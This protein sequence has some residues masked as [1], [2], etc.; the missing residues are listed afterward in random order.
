[1]GLS[2]LIVVLNSLRLAG[3][4]EPGS[5][6]WAAAGSCVG[7]RGLALSVALPGGAVRRLVLIGQVVSPARGQSLL[8]TLP[9]ITTIGLPNG[10]SAETYLEPG[11]VG[12]EPVPSH[13]RRSSLGSED[14][15]SRA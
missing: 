8:P 13:L 10:G 11:A 12:R 4:V 6:T 1:M 2:S 14:R 9:S 15:T 3:W 5:T 7:R